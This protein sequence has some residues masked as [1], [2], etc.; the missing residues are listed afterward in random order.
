MTVEYD[1]DPDFDEYTLEQKITLL[2][3]HCEVL[4]ENLEELWQQE[5]GLKKANQK[6]ALKRQIDSTVNELRYGQQQLEHLKRANLVQGET[7]ENLNASI[8]QAFQHIPLLPSF[9]LSLPLFTELKKLLLAKP[10][11]E[12]VSDGQKMPLLIQA[13]SGVGKSTLA[14]MIAYDEEIKSR[15]STGIFWLGLGQDADI[16]PHQLHLIQVIDTNAPA[17]IDPEHATAF[18]RQ[19]C[20]PRSCLII[21]D[22]VHD[23]RDI[24]AFNALGENCQLLITTANKEVA[25]Y[26]RH[27]IPSVKIYAMPP[28]TAEQGQTYMQHYAPA[29]FCQDATQLDKLLSACEYR[30]LTI[31]YLSMLAEQVKKPQQLLNQL[32]TDV[33][34][35]PEHCPPHLIRSLHF[36]INQLGEDPAEC[37][38]T[39]GAFANYKRI[40]QAT[41]V[42]LWNY[43][44]HLPE[45][46]AHSFLHL[47]ADKHLLQVDGY[48]ANRYIQLN[49]FQHDYLC[50]VTDLQKLNTHLLAAYRRQ[51]GQHGWVSGPNDGYFFEYLGLHLHAVGR[52]KELKMLLLDFDWLHTKLQVSGLYS[53]LNDYLLLEGSEFEQVEQALRQSA[54]VLLKDK[55][56]LATQLLTHLWAKPSLEIQKLLRQAKEMA[57]D[58]KP[59]RSSS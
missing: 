20:Q 6:Q 32:Q 33:C 12:E 30:P 52:E 31:H 46:R 37:Y 27:F 16:L 14:M 57:P 43:L 13:P 47:F 50:E 41:V 7:A 40:P 54:S 3:Q 55:N 36:T 22:D 17:F 39:L 11:L 53:L 8:T 19:I 10:S 28:F 58:W 9:L 25:Q 42:M 24:L 48:A 35:I 56:Q 59:K 18:L 51:C 4:Q 49:T 45:E 29:A 38:L 2:E 15:F 26:I 1:L 34:P 23:V 21:L 5:K 44:Y